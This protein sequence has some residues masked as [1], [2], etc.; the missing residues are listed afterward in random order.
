MYSIFE[1]LF[2]F[3]ISHSKCDY[4]DDFVDRLNRKY[5]VVIILTFVTVLTSKQYIGEPLACFCPAHFT[6]AH[7]E[8]TNNICWISKS[9]FVPFETVSSKNDIEKKYSN[10]FNFKLNNHLLFKNNSNIKLLKIENLITFYPFILIFQ[11]ILFY[12]PYFCW[13]QIIKKSVYDVSTLVQIALDSQKVKNQKGKEM[14][15]YLVN[16]L[17]RSN[18]YYSRYL[19]KN[20]NPFSQNFN[21]KMHFENYNCERK[22]LNIQK[23]NSFFSFEAEKKNEIGT[24]NPQKKFKKSYF[25]SYKLG[26]FSIY[27]II[28][29]LYLLNC[30]CQFLVLNILI[31]QEI[32]SNEL[33]KVNY[34]IDYTFSTN[35]ILANGML[36]A[37]KTIKNIIEKGII[38]RENNRVLMFHSV[39]FCDFKIRTLGDRLHRHTVQCVVPVNIFTEKIFMIIWFWLLILI[40]INIYNFIAWSIFYFSRKIKFQFLKRNI[41]K[42][43]HSCKITRSKKINS[44]F[45]PFCFKENI[46]RND[47]EMVLIENMTKNNLLIDNIFILKLIS[48]NSNEILTRELVSLIVKNINEKYYFLC[49]ENTV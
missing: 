17:E 21:N 25:K 1:F 47:W 14:L 11:A 49:D 29:I 3:I 40:L 31:S 34:I 18:E 41:L 16:H 46:S 24:L 12:F 35:T 7:V 19:I 48:K 13:K 45:Y 8:Y 27:L 44:H 38:F 30:F 42:T 37:F 6:G 26:L 9:F 32:K 10:D 39:I 43:G 36:F 23:I 15:K 4:C 2:Q 33:N 5:T 22:K 20:L 28:K